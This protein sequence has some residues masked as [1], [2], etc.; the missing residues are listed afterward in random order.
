MRTASDA[1]GDI[2]EGRDEP[3]YYDCHNR[4]GGV[5][6]GGVRA[7]GGGATC[8]TESPTVDWVYPSQAPSYVE[9]N[10]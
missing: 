2:E 10:R 4:P 7:A 5:A 9:V 3:D 8:V 1:S 6:G